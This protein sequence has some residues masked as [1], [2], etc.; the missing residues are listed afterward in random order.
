[1]H[2]TDP[3]AMRALAHPARLQIM[4][5]LMADG[6]A[7]A[8]QCAEVT[9]LSPSACSYHLRTLGR[10]GFAAED[11]ASAADGRQRPWRAL[12]VSLTLAGPADQPDAA[13]PAAGALIQ[14]ARA[15]IER[16]RASYE[17]REP[18]FPPE[19]RAAGGWTEDVLHVTAAELEQFRLQVQELAARY[20]RRD[21][22]QRPSDARRVHLVL[23]TTPWFDPAKES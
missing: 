13:K 8:T 6:P 16:I 1:M 4:E 21:P 15:R 9:G 22:A 3:R 19:W 12:A 20:R 14:A 23:D 7:T 17:E 18:D 2:I 5:K 10:Y 11:P